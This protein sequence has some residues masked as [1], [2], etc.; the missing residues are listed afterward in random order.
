MA[1]HPT[2]RM[3]ENAVLAHLGGTPLNEAASLAFIEPADLADALQLYKAAGR[4]AL[5]QQPDLED[6]HQVRIEFSDFGTAEQAAVTHLR[7]LMR[8]AESAGTLSSWWFIRKAP[9]WRLR[10]QPGSAATLP[11]MKTHLARALDDLATRREIAGWEQTIYEPETYVFGGPEGIKAAHSLFHSDSR[12]IL[13]YLHH[14]TTGNSEHQLGRRE[15]SILLMSAL[16]RGAGQEWS[17]QGDIWHRTTRMRPVPAATPLAKLHRMEPAL[18]HLMTVDV[19][20][21][22]TLTNENGPLS[23]L[24]GWIAAVEEAGRVLGTLAHDGRLGKGIRE[25]LAR[26]VIFHWNR[27][28]L[29]THSQGVLALAAR[30]AVMDR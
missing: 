18:R 9:D 21:A 28:G 20:P 27:I 7:P 11:Q 16:F 3:V 10:C 22:S 15:I 30:T 24:S 12:K 6:W 14:T 26:H 2:P 29:P 8:E 19:N 17:E 23:H 1:D 4:T 13:D 5:A 25:T